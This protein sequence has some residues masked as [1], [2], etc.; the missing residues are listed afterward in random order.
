VQILRKFS[1]RTLF[2]IHQAQEGNLRH[3][4]DFRAREHRHDGDRCVVIFRKHNMIALRLAHLARSTTT[5]L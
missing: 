4:G 1:P 2:C 5:N 3:D